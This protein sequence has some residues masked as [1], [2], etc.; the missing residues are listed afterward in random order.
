MEKT[1]NIIESLSLFNNLSFTKK[2]WDIILKGCGCPK[3]THFWSALKQFCIVKEGKF[4]TL[5]DL[6]AEIF[7]NV[8][9]AYCKVNRESVN[10]CYR[11]K[12][13]RAKLASNPIKHT[14]FYNV[15]GVILTENPYINE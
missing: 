7:A 8:W 13:V 1:I 11:K 6:N 15:N 4:F 5:V 3:S 2:Q 12:Q 9:H 14:T 10:K